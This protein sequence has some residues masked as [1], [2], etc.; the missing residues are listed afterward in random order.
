ML[1]TI[2]SLN[3]SILIGLFNLIQ[4]SVWVILDDIEIINWTRLSLRSFPVFLLSVDI[5]ADPI[6]IIHDILYALVILDCIKLFSS[7]NFLVS[8]L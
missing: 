3:D 7:T 6:W 4:Y 8:K 2:I 1:D 5:I